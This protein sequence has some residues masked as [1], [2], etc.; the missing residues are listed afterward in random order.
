[1]GFMLVS[2]VCRLYQRL[3]LVALV[4]SG[5]T[6]LAIDINLP[7]ITVSF[8][9]YTPGHEVGEAPIILFVEEQMTDPAAK[10]LL[11]VF[12]VDDLQ[13]GLGVARP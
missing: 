12:V 4:P 2:Y 6:Y 3:S 10:R 13:H 7:S 1:M 11:I 9:T 5:K 8:C